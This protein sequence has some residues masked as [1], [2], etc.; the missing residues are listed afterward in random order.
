[1]SIREDRVSIGV[2]AISDFGLSEFPLPDKWYVGNLVQ[3]IFMR[4]YYA[5]VVES[6]SKWKPTAVYWVN[7]LADIRD[8]LRRK[9]NIYL[10]YVREDG[11]FLGQWDIVNKSKYKKVK[12]R[13]AKEL[14]TRITNYS[15]NLSVAA[16]RW[17][18]Q[19]PSFEIVPQLPAP[20]EKF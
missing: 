20:R 8:V 4:E 7:A 3:R 14:E 11:S 1:M 17:Q 15:E 16:K 2:S 10:E 12:A 9:Y 6:G 13:E 5:E 18:L 19:L